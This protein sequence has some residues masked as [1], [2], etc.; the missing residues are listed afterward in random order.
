MSEKREKNIRKAVRKEF[1]K[2]LKV[3]LDKKGF[4][5]RI[6]FAFKIIFKKINEENK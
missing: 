4:F 1:K 6:I 5:Q 3:E 2:W